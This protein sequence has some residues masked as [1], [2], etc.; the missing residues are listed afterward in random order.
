MKLFKID[1]GNLVEIESI[2]KFIAVRLFNGVG[3]F[4]TLKIVNSKPVFLKEHIKRLSDSAEKVWNRKFDGEQIFISS[5]EVARQKEFGMMRIFLVE[6]NLEF[7]FFF[8]VD[9]FPYS[10]TSDLCVKILEYERNPSGFSAGLKPISYFE[11]VVIRE[12]LKRSGFDEGVFLSNGYIAEGT[13]TN[14]F[15]IKDNKVFTPPLHL[16]VLNGITR[17]KIFQICQSN[18]IYIEEVEKKPE[19]LLSADECFLSSSLLG[20]GA[21]SKIFLPDGT[22]KIFSYSKDS[23]SYF[24]KSKLEELEKKDIAN[25]SSFY[26]IL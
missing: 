11:N 9:D 5:L 16:G 24:L 20:V 26:S 2:D 3:L 25:V 10:K 4:E 17:Q 8:L 7:S 21:V 23:L 14:I 22:E 12:K 1:N 13:R 15:W 19:D 6:H 18:S